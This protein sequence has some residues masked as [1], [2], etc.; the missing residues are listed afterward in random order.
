MKAEAIEALRKERN[1]KVKELVDKIR[2]IQSNNA[3]TEAYR[4]EA[5]RKLREEIEKVKVEAHPTIVAV[6]DK[7]ELNV[8]QNLAEAQFEFVP[9]DLLPEEVAKKT[10]LEGKNIAFANALYEQYLN[11]NEKRREALVSDAR[12]AVYNDF[13]NKEGYIKALEMLSDK[14]HEFEVLHEL[15]EYIQ[16]QAITENEKRWSAELASF[17]KQKQE[18]AYEIVNE[19]HLLDLQLWAREVLEKEL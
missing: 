10:L 6:I 7:V 18:Y 5:A 1:A 17:N 14:Y 13:P 8:K 15:S 19:S 16:E 3:Y 11:A 12:L 2:E 4:F 9:K